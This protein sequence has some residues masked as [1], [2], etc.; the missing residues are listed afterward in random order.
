MADEDQQRERVRA[1]FAAR[2]AEKYRRKQ[3]A[4]RRGRSGVDGR[5]A[6]PDEGGTRFIEPGPG[7]LRR[8]G[9]LI[10]PFTR[11]AES[12]PDR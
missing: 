6:I 8:I 2:R 1:T 3:R 4:A 10:R 9:R 12:S 5:L 11:G 7:A